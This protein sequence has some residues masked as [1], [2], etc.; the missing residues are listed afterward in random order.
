MH[1]EWIQDIR[2]FQA[3]ILRTITQLKFLPS[4]Q[5]EE[6]YHLRPTTLCNNQIATYAYTNKE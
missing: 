6:R 3:K 1:V 2:I 4:I 5:Y